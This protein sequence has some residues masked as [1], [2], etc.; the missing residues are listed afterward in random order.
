MKRENLKLLKKCWAITKPYWVSEEK[1][2][3]WA[4][5]F[6]LILT[7]VAFNSLLVVGSFQQRY[8]MSALADKD[9]TRFLQSLMIT[10]CVHLVLNPVTALNKYL[11]NKISLSWRRWMT[12]HFLSD[13]LKQRNFYKLNSLTNVDNPDDRIADDIKYFT[14]RGAVFF[15]QIIRTIMQVIS[16]TGVLWSISHA[17]T[18]YIVI[19]TIFGTFMTIKFLG[20]QLVGLHF[21]QRKK[22]ADF[23]FGLIRIREN[24]ESIAF[25]RGEVHEKVRISQRF[26]EVFNNENQLIKWDLA[27]NLVQEFFERFTYIIPALVLSPQVLSGQIDIGVI[28]Q[29]NGAFLNIFHS[30]KLIV[31]WF[32]QIADFTAAIDRLGT[33]KNSL[34]V[35][36]KDGKSVTHRMDRNSDSSM[37]SKIE[38]LEDSRLSLD[39]LT[40]QTPNYQRILVNNL[41]VTMQPG[42]SLLI[43]G[44]SGCGK[45]SLLRA[46]AGLWDSGCG[47][48]VRPKIEEILFLPQQP[49]M[50][51][52]SLRDQLLYPHNFNIKDEE[53]YRALQQV[54]L[55]SLAERFGSLDAEADWAK[56]LSLGEQQRLAF[57]RLLLCKPR[58]A[59]LDEATSALDIENEGSLYRHLIESSTTFFSV[60]HRPTLVKYHQYILDLSVNESWQLIPTEKYIFSA[61]I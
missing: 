15:P 40:L 24:A 38:M 4:M 30:M 60:G 20:P 16:F 5:L 8:Q 49:Y 26:K 41:S 59:L 25:Y 52:G 32:D 35:E 48:I 1:W 28:P 34:E 13:Y 10:F 46:I 12:E 51:L 29:G 39:H 45:S 33:F 11:E 14:E 27:L 47:T 31:M 53:L 54:N 23:R 21:W 6:L 43:V 37:K 55:S 22:E 36:D 2:G 50:I 9:G 17:L 56:V 57:A 42:E 19:Y 58:Y 61:Y 44:S 3:A 18:F 7:M